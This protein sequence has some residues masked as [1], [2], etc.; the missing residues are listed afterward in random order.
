MYTLLSP[1]SQGPCMEKPGPHT[2]PILVFFPTKPHI[3]MQETHVLYLL[4][5]NLRNKCMVCN[6][7]QNDLYIAS[8]LHPLLKMI[9][10]RIEG[11]LKS[12]I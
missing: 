11:F 3:K 2:I 12:I 8:I 6:Y 7:S 1:F 4:N 5:V 9:L 10:L